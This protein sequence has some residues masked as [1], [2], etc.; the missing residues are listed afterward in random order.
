MERAVIFITANETVVSN[1]LYDYRDEILVDVHTGELSIIWKGQRR[2]RQDYIAVN[3]NREVHICARKR[4]GQYYSYYGILDNDSAMIMYSGNRSVGDPRAYFFRI[5]DGK[6]P[7]RTLLSGPLP[8]QKQA[9]QS[10][11]FRYNGGCC[12]I[13]KVWDSTILYD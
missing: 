13:Y 11:G 4:R 10:M 2:G 3:G 5:L 7:T 9:I 12:G 8:P 6:F 1:K